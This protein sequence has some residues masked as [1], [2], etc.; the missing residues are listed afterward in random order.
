MGRKH[1]WPPTVHVHSKGQAFVRWKGRTYYLGAHDSPE[2]PERVAQ[3]Q[4]D[5]L[6][7]QPPESRGGKATRSTITVAEVAARFLAYSETSTDRSKRE[8]KN[9]EYSFAPLLALFASTPAAEFGAK[10]LGQVQAEMVRLQWSARVTNR[11]IVR[12]RTAW[13]WAE[14][15]ELVPD[16]RW[17]NL[18]SLRGLRT[19]ASPRPA[20]HLEQ[21]RLILSHLPFTARDLVL[22]Q[23]WSGMRP[24]EA[25]TMR[26]EHIDRSGPIWVFT[27]LDDAGSPDHKNDWRQGDTGRHVLLGPKCQA[28]LKRRL[29]GKTA[30]YVFET[31]SERCYT[32]MSYAQ[33]VRK[34][35]AAAGGVAFTPY[36]LRHGAKQRI[37]RELGLDAARAFL[38]Q[39]SL[40]TTNLYAAAQ[41]VDLAKKA[42]KRC[43]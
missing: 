30:G 43:G 18:R 6:T 1:V 26:I 4:V 20:I 41:D 24:A 14:T 31:S 21:I 35:C 3:L 37:T 38:G 27:P 7:G 11:R 15:Q 36:A 22:V 25:R 16:G 17:A 10:A 33:T 32:D 40:G 5:L 34:A 29:T 9:F 8:T 2:L 12:I 23:Y 42:A 19:K 28:V 39:K 13:R